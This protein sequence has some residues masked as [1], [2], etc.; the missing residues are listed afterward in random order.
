MDSNSEMTT[1]KAKCK[2]PNRF[3]ILGDC[4]NKLYPFLVKR[5]KNIR[6]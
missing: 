4:F 3:D 2:Q 5:D 1:G 6:S